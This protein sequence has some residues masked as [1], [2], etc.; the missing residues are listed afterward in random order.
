MAMNYGF[1][2]SDFCQLAFLAEACCGELSGWV[3][4]P[5]VPQ[6]LTSLPSVLPSGLTWSALSSNLGS[7]FPLLFPT[8]FLS[9]SLLILPSQC[10]TQLLALNSDHGAI[11]K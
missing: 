5:Q 1:C 10:F 11:G 6:S 3:P 7:M 8:L 2:S 4:G 9:V